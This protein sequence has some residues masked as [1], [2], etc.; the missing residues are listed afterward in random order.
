[1]VYDAAYFE[2]HCGNPY[3]RDYPGWAEFYGRIASA[4]V[5]EL[6]P[7][8]VLDAGCAIGFLV[9][10]LRKLG[11][12]A[13]GVDVSEYAISQ[14]PENIREHV[15]VGSITHELP[16]SYGLITCIE[17][18][19]HLDAADGDAAIANLCA[20]TDLVLFSSTPDDTTEPTHVNVQPVSYW[21]ERFARHG[22]FRDEVFDA[23]VVAAHAL[24][25]RRGEPALV[26]AR[27]EL[28]RTDLLRTSAELADAR[29]R[30][31]S[32]QEE[33]V[34]LAAV[35]RSV[36]ADQA[37]LEGELERTRRRLRE[38]EEWRQRGGWRVYEALFSLRARA[39]PTGTRRDR[40][41]R[42]M[43]GRTAMLLERGV[44]RRPAAAA[45]R[46]ES[47]TG[48]VLIIS[49]CPGDA[50][51]YRG[52]HQAEQLRSAGATADA[53]L[54]D[55]VD[56]A[57]ALD[58]YSAFVLHRVAWDTSIEDFVSA[59]RERGKRISFDTDDLVFQPAALPY[60]AALD[61]LSADER[62]LY[63]DGI[64]RYRRSMSELDGVTVSTD[65]LTEAAVAVARQVEIVP[66]AVSDEMVRL[67]DSALRLP[68]PRSE[69]VTIAYLSGTPT[70]DRDF[71]E[72]ADAV[73]WALDTYPAVR[74][75]VVGHLRLDSRFGGFERRRVEH[76]PLQPWTA[77]PDLLRGVDVNLA[78]LEPE[79]PF[80]EAK[81]CLKY[82]E[83]ALVGVPTIASPRSDFRRVIRHGE[84]GLLAE[85]RDD[86]REA[87]RF[88]I[89]EHDERIRIG[90]AAFDD[91]RTNHTTR[92]RSRSAHAAFGRLLGTSVD[93]ALT[94]NWVLRA[95]IAH[96]GGGYRTIFRLAESLA[97]RGHTVRCHVERV[98][99]LEGLSR[100]AAAEFVENAFGP[101][102]SEVRVDAPLRP[103]DI[104]IATNWPTAP[105]VAAHPASLFK[106][107][108]IQDYEPAFYDE[109]D[110][111]AA[112]AEATYLLPLRHICY[113]KQLADVLTVHTGRQ[114]DHL[115]FALEPCFRQTIAPAERSRARKVLFLARPDQARRG[116]ETG[117][118]AL[119]RVKRDDPETEI[120]LFGATDEEL[121]PLPFPARNL[122]VLRPSELAAVLNESHVFL[123]F[124]L[125]NI[126]H[127]P[128]EAMA[129]GCAVVEA[130]VP[131]VRSMV[132]PGSCL[133]TV[134]EPDAVAA[135]IRTLLADDELRIGYAA[136]GVEATAGLT[137][138]AAGD[139]FE[140]IL[141]S[142]AFL[143]LPAR[144]R[145]RGRA[146]S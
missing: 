11:V 90:R 88:L 136:R 32:A 65:F 100:A 123:S 33:L 87:L 13:F 145:P 46:G 126:S 134:P 115:D 19:E 48:G 6:R 15:W 4:I 121:S 72:A 137:W 50:Y 56:L 54:L 85:G 129:C 70:H 61:N 114:A 47:L 132:A 55:S 60:V 103:A 140:A 68:A 74:L 69:L 94:V 101:L 118:A 111:L 66:N 117:I 91:V 81:S 73:L 113:G 76:M 97:A 63:V 16:R 105:L 120:L 43:L 131:T 109:A 127:A 133:L 27:N 96:R 42:S 139:R 98:A 57:T 49:G 116:Y 35:V 24:L 106:A 86:W 104:T 17:V 82:L 31:A 99:H 112:D 34:S 9:E 119:E 37:R 125:T 45:A 124:S 51:R 144:K 3:R 77:L 40:L 122:G 41:V 58:S 95:P 21:V 102:R 130:D 44:V 10:E 26:A 23:S 59:V 107:Y 5:R 143:R 18:L 67:A 53:A 22:F 36:R 29:G 108:F 52:E 71:L 93:E 89:E 135:A 30:L 7:R 64:H 20:H 28:L 92:A 79:N 1:M 12:E 2:S 25:F 84:N 141:R 39:A 80:T 110:P 14:V 83:A 128:Y 138:K 38:W 146:G 8:S 78:P 75:L 62:A 142:L